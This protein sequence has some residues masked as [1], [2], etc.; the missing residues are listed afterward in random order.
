MISKIRIQNFKCFKDTGEINIKPITIFVGPNSSGK[1]SI[2][3][4]LLMLRQTIDSTDVR[5]SLS[6]N[7]KWIEVGSYPEFIY[8]GNLENNIQIF[9]EFFGKQRTNR[10]RKPVGDK[11][12]SLNAVFKY[13]KNTTQ[14]KL[15]E[16]VI[17]FENAEQIIR[18][19]ES[20]RSYSLTINYQHKDIL[21]TLENK[22][23]KPVKFYNY[24]LQTRNLKFFYE[25]VEA[26]I[27]RLEAP[28][29]KN[30]E[31]IFYL[32][33]LRDFPKRVYFPTGEEPEDVGIRGE[34][35]VD[36]FWFSHL[37][38]NERLKH[39]EDITQ[40][41]FNL[42]EFAIEI[43]LE[44]LGRNTTYYRVVLIDKHNKFPAN[45]TDVGFG[46]SQTLP[47][48]IESF[49][50]PPNSLVLIE[51]PE[52]HLHP[53]AQA[54]LGDLFI[55]AISTEN[56]K[57]IIETHSEHMLARIRRRIAEKKVDKNDVAI[58]YFNPTSEG[59]VIEEVTLNENGQYESFPKGFFEEDI[60]EAFEHLKAMK[61]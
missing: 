17:K 21:K 58:Y 61:Q 37:T 16:S 29:E 11:K 38:G 8:K 35:A 25:L 46:V 18:L 3:K 9:V 28:I 33:P 6:P 49:Y 30:F 4:M 13:N 36:A 31:N 14:I 12:F 50:A 15:V 53:K 26:N 60:T 20:G 23:I 41:W 5:N 2:L 55:E 32:G 10:R 54:I 7:G 45:L 44:K 22:K 24:Q 59:T 40:K 47:I 51:Q 43:K 57:F 48:I 56:K 42:F 27:Y 39:L 34:R 1:S 19:N 52:I